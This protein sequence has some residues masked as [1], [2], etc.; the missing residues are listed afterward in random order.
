MSPF[1]PPAHPTET[2]IT[3]Q[4]V[5]TTA[6]SGNSMSSLSNASTSTLSPNESI[7]AATAIGASA[8]STTTTS[9]SPASPS[10]TA[11]TTASATAANMQKKRGNGLCRKRKSKM[12]GSY[13]A[14]EDSDRKRAKKLPKG[15]YSEDNIDNEDD[16]DERTLGNTSVHQERCHMI[17]LAYLHVLKA[18]PMSKWNDGD[19]PRTISDD[20]RSII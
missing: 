19:E 16:I 4:V 9:T 2:P 14:P 1:S 7:S 11:L 10:T 13:T 8:V 6:Q 15:F 20:V 12:Q 3:H 18:P 5:P 17:S